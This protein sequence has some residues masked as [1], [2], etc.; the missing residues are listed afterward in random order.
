MRAG[1]PATNWTPRAP[2]GTPRGGRGGRRRSWSHG[3]SAGEADTVPYRR[4]Q[5]LEKLKAAHM[6][7]TRQVR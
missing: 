6:P 5:G 4:A 2:A 3:S 1:E 7:P